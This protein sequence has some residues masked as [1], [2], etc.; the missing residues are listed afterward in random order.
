[1]KSATQFLRMPR[2]A[3]LFLQTLVLA[4]AL[5]VAG[6]G[7]PDKAAAK[8]Y[9][10]GPQDRI[11]VLVFEW[12]ASRDEFFE[13]TAL[14]DEFTISADGNL[15]LPLIGEVRAAGTGTGDL[16][17][18]ISARL[19]A[20]MGLGRRPVIAIEVVKF[21]PIYITGDVQVPGEFPYRPGLSVL[22]ALSLAGGLQRYSDRALMRVE[23]ES[24]ATRG[25]LNILDI[26]MKSMIARRARLQAE[27]DRAET[28]SFPQDWRSKQVEA[29]ITIFMRQEQQI[30]DARREAF[31][32]QMEALEQL[33]KYLDKEIDS[34]NAQID[35]E[36]TQLKLLKK[37]LQSVTSLVE[38]GLAVT[39]RQLSL[40]RTMA[41][42]E[43][44]R[45]RLG[46]NLLRARQEISKT[47]IAI[48][49]LRNKRN[50]EITVDLR[51]TQSRLEE[52]TQKIETSEQL[53]DESTAFQSRAD[54]ARDRNVKPI[55]T[56]MRRE[57]A[58]M[59]QIDANEGTGVEP[60][61]TIQVVV[62]G[63]VGRTP[64]MRSD[65]GASTQSDAAPRLSRGEV[66]PS[67]SR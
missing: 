48:I 57:G 35:T 42:I 51:E 3:A 2:R 52:L 61:D 64:S 39:P 14:N 37:E 58:Q 30:F 8:E 13:W 10:L 34:L 59:V 29:P 27:F 56:I 33:K 9:I 60:G 46:T 17:K 54:F 5:L 40:E 15:S 6:D 62:P 32:T 63:A 28:I 67:Q 47:D 36:D 44:D 66:A 23:R 7:A 38:K 11:R 31:N 43:G 20:E 1:M 53:L 50:N 4:A 22:Q 21:R 16:A 26:Q 45:L 24:I 12:R 18:A 25:E 55:Y 49:E 19:Q 41:Q 65:R